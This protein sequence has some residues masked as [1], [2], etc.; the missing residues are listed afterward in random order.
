M[1]FL[2]TMGASIS[3]L[4]LLIFGTWLTF[5][6]WGVEVG[7]LLNTTSL[8]I[9]GAII[10]L[11][12]AWI[13]FKPI[14]GRIVTTGTMLLIMF[15]LWEI[16]PGYLTETF[17]LN[18]IFAKGTTGILIAGIL[19]WS[20]CVIPSEPPHMGLLTIFFIRV[21]IALK[22][23]MHFLPF[24]GILFGVILENMVVKKPDLPEQEVRLP[25]KMPAGISGK[26]WF[27]PDPEN[28]INY[29]NQG[30]EEGVTDGLVSIWKGVIREYSVV[31]HGGPQN[32]MEFLGSHIEAIDTILKEFCRNSLP[33]IPSTVPTHILFKYFAR[34]Q[35]KPTETEAKTWGPNKEF[36]YEEYGN[37]GKVTQ[38]VNEEVV[39]G[40]YGPNGLEKLKDAVQKRMAAITAVRQGRGQIRKPEWGIIINLLTL[41]E[42][43][44]E[45]QSATAMD[46]EVKE[47]FETNAD[48]IEMAN[49]LERAASIY[50]AAKKA[51]TPMPFHRCLTKAQIE[52][53]KSDE[54]VFTIP[55]LDNLVESSPEII[56]LII[57]EL[58]GGKNE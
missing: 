22:E 52:A 37:W 27:T 33:V 42:P 40:K 44:P 18:S 53:G 4:I 47:S 29:M 8:I 14:A 3:I 13:F 57:S 20:Y 28:F 1:K 51:G 16:L 54:K 12:I 10:L 2:K 17:K 45:G 56:K 30:A 19:V 24:R 11:A 48:K 15:L 46:L 5:R 38:I 32:I 25:D 43:K 23:G 49:R 34:P 35:K 9:T 50:K 41:T 21:P 55:G 58:K 26:V 36:P 39:N 7:V 31:L 6:Y